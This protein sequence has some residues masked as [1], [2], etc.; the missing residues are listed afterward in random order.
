MP[1][2]DLPIHDPESEVEA[3]AFFPHPRSALLEAV[4]DSRNEFFEKVNHGAIVRDAD[5]RSETVT[6]GEPL[7]ERR[8]PGALRACREKRGR[9]LPLLWVRAEQVAHYRRLWKP[10][11][12]LIGETL[13]QL[14]EDEDLKEL[15]FAKENLSEA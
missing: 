3:P 11:F 10:P 14:F 7:K 5:P 9:R 13:P 12:P 8:R 4:P 1:L 15:G 6:R 2:R